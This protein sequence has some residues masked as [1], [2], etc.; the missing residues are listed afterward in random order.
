MKRTKQFLSL[1]LVLCLVVGLIPSTAF[2][3]SGNHFFTDVATNAW[4]S[5]AVQYVYDHDMMNGTGSGKF[6]PDSFT[7][8]GMVIT[9]LHRIEGLPTASGVDFVDVPAGQWYTNAVAWGSESGI[10]NGH[11]N[12]QFC[13]NDPITREQMA[14]I[15]Y[16]YAKY[17]GYDT[18]ITG[19]TA[20][21]FDEDKIDSYAVDAI[22]WML[23]IGLIEGTDRNTLDPLGSATRA[24]A[25]TILMRFC[26]KYVFASYTVTFN[27]NYKGAS[28]PET[29]EVE[30]GQMVSAPIN[31]SRSGYTFGG[32]YTKIS[33]GTKF[34]FNTTITDDLTLYA[35]WTG[36]SGGGGGS[37]SGGGGGAIGSNTGTYQIIFESN[38]G[39]A[40]IY[41]TQQVNAGATVRK[42]EDPTRELYRF[43]GWYLEAAA[44]TEYDF[45]NPAASNLTLYAG[46]GNPNG[47]TDDL[48]AASNETETIY[49]I[50]DIEVS[51]SDVV[52]TYNTNDVALIGVEFFV[53]EMTNGNWDEDVLNANLNRG[54]VA[55]ASGYTEQYGELATVTF[56]ISGTLPEY[57][58][59]RATMY[60][61]DSEDPLTDY[62]TARY[63]STYTDFNAQTVEDFEQDLVLNFDEDTTTNFGVLNDSVIVVPSD[64]RFANDQE[65]VVE[66]LDDEDIS[67]LA[68]DW[69]AEEYE[70][71]LEDL[72]PEHLF[73]F[74]DKD[75]VISENEDGT[76]R[77]LSDLREG[78][79]IYIEDT[80]WMFKIATATENADGS[81]SFTQDKD[82]DMTDFYDVLKVDFEGV[83]A[84][85]ETGDVQ[86]LWEIVDVDASGSV[87]I[88]PFKIEHEFSNGVKLGGSISGKVT[89]NVKVFYDA[90]LFSADY[91]EAS[92]TFSTE[93]TGEV[94]AEVS[95]DNNNE[96]Q[97]VVFQVDTRK[98]KLPT[99]VTGLD[100]YIKP[101]AQI[102][103]KLSG[104][105]SINWTSKQTSGFK[106]N[107]DT[108]RTDIKKKENIVSVMAKGKAEAKVGPIIDIG[109]ELL[110]GVLSG[111]VVAEA[112]AKFTAEAVI[113]LNNDLTNTAD[114][115]H[116]CGLCISGKA[117]WYASASAKISY[118]FTNH[119][120]GDIVNAKI[121]DFTAPITFNAIPGQFFVSVL[122]AVDSPFGAKLKFGG[123]ECTNK[124][125]RT[126]FKTLDQNGQDIDGIQV[127]VVKQ[128]QTTSKSGTSPYVVYLYDGTYTASANINGAN[129]SK[130]LAVSGNRQTVTLSKSTA[131]TVL[132]G[133]VLDA[134]TR[135]TIAG[136]TV[137]VK[138]GNVVVASTTT[139]SSGK[140]SVAVSN[141]SLTVEISKANYLPFGSTE[142]VYEGEPT[143]SMGQ[144]ELAPGTGMGGFHGVIRDAA[145]NEPLADVTLNLYEGWNNPAASNTSTRTLKTDSNGRFRYDT[146]MLFGSVRGLPSG[147]YT[148]TASKAGYSNTSYNIV[149]YPGT[150]DQNPAINET[151]SPE[152]SGDLYRI[153]LTWGQNPWDLDS[154][155]VAGTN[156][157]SDIHVFFDS[158]DPAPHYANLDI[159]DIDSYG[160]ETITITNFDGLSNIRYAVH[161][162]TN[163]DKT[164][165]TALA[166]SGAVVRLYKGS[167]LLR[168]FNVPTGYDGTEWDIF[169][170]DPTGRITVINTMTYADDPWQVL[171][172]TRTMSVSEKVNLL[173]V[174]EVTEVNE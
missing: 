69:T 49:S 41:Q 6:S 101:S 128:G 170:L 90:H 46:W 57:F 87:G 72:V 8:R 44:V 56:P 131:D 53:D 164:T 149:I 27:L 23:G 94:K 82:V 95:A 58:V 155:L 15:L 77:T 158:M 36:A 83:E 145:T 33:G 13:P 107:S 17:K 2:A 147:N 50:S 138:N 42:P 114:S 111:G 116:A 9:I 151:M 52:I 154:H 102:N 91:C 108:G 62:V 93:I 85:T 71:Q 32:W 103:W 159:D 37:S 171:G 160:P 157:G 51:G 80:T 19:N 134:N 105:V 135:S 130:T 73:T 129:V 150:T 5:D 21:F 142:T 156:T 165:S 166:N 79:I 137:K 65:F 48:Y 26:K 12:G 98:V 139:N 78:D 61:A 68:D 173:K 121:L 148:L 20:G 75:A 123:G 162:F 140:F 66:D 38:D 4:Y 117:D 141:G 54:A 153:V 120:K 122:N 97:N 81:I 88:G 18:T 132:E 113:P 161:D 25:A 99:P 34:D 167:Q 119:F 115:K 22:K 70:P 47:S 67:A 169:T 118:K 55:T 124:T 92:V 14:T 84:E 89:G 152:M 40:N 127:S 35:R 126:E 30:E 136:A 125:Y 29:V 39:T 106:Y 110:G 63:T 11:G 163:L 143:H 64:C 146:T 144:V 96:Y 45:N 74:P 76:V 104:D 174:Y 31:P 172:G 112:G 7:S 24:Q 59:V 86:L 1:L 168:T 43:T 3:T 100:I 109:L 16:R 60:G 133:T 28:D 10:I